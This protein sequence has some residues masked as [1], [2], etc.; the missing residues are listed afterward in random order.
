MSVNG[1]DRWNPWNSCLNFGPI[2]RGF[3][4]TAVPPIHSARSARDPRAITC[5]LPPRLCRSPHGPT[6]R[7]WATPLRPR[8]LSPRPS[9]SPPLPVPPPGAPWRA[10]GRDLDRDL[11]P[12][13]LPPDLPPPTKQPG[14]LRRSTPTRG[15]WV[16]RRGFSRA[17]VPRFARAPF[18][19][20]PLDFGPKPPATPEVRTIRSPWD[21]SPSGTSKTSRSLRLA[22]RLPPTLP[23]SLP[24]PR[25]RSPLRPPRTSATMDAGLTPESTSWP[26][27]EA[28]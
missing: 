23:R 5:R 18:G 11:G 27:T 15:Q 4:Q 3:H 20:W 6:A 10:A 7:R 16:R 19:R 1:V 26:P 17:K 24:P 12:K 25:G 8:E 22:A 14:G 2:P 28:E 21:Q 13:R 9:A